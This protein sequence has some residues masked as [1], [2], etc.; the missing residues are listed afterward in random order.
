MCQALAR[1][2]K[3]L[4]L[5][6]ENA[7]CKLVEPL[8]KTKNQH[9]MSKQEYALWSCNTLVGMSSQEMHTHVCQK[10]AGSTL[11]KSGDRE[12][13]EW[14]HF[15]QAAKLSTLWRLWFEGR[16][17]QFSFLF[18]VAQELKLLSLSVLH[19]CLYA[20]RLCINAEHTSNC[21][22]P[23]PH[24]HRTQILGS[25][26]PGSSCR[27]PHIWLTA[28]LDQSEGY[29]CR[30]DYSQGRDFYCENSELYFLLWNTT[31]FCLA[32]L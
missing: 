1:T 13:T 18:E 16:K 32:V 22:S 8:W 2:V 26:P 4:G 9:L 30:T 21:K 11:G 27:P 3:W 20:R 15:N 23:S 24:P 6:W 19:P 17:K 25:R 12:N 7:R 14:S 29:K 28:T 5:A 31:G 10:K